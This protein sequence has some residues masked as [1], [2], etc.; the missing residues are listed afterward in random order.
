MIFFPWQKASLWSQIISL[1][2]STLKVKLPN[3]SSNQCPNKFASEIELR[4]WYCWCFLCIIRTAIDLSSW[5]FLRLSILTNF[6][7]WNWLICLHTIIFY[8]IHWFCTS[9]IKLSKMQVLLTN[10][11]N[12]FLICWDLYDHY[13]FILYV[14]LDILLQRVFCLV[15]F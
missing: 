1:G 6:L 4:L 3:Y 14:Y 9:S 10:F 2:T 8:L 13:K 15:L 7:I 11:N 12:M 5:P